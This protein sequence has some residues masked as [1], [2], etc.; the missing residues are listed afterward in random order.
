LLEPQY[1]FE[2]DGAVEKVR[3][4]LQTE[5]M[6]KFRSDFLDYHV[7]D[8]AQIYLALSPEERITMY[9]YLSANE[10]ADMFEIIEEDVE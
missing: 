5:D 10:M 8:Q 1:E 3:E 2:L 9:H 7:Y 4:S 6:E